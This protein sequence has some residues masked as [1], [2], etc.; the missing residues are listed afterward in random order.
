MAKISLYCLFFVDFLISA[1][2]SLAHLNP[3]NYYDLK[4]VNFP[5]PLGSNIEG[6]VVNP[7]DGG[8]PYALESFDPVSAAKYSVTT[9]VASAQAS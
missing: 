5:T 1:P 2:F 7:M 4:T 8:S 9:A 6:M 3:K